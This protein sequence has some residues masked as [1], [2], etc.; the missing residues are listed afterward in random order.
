M[1]Q[2]N[3]LHVGKKW[4]G[5][6]IFGRTKWLWARSMGQTFIC[7]VL[8]VRRVVRNKPFNVYL[9]LGNGLENL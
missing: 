2:A 5:V 4:A 3:M 1:Y 9:V 8:L 6:N 7:V